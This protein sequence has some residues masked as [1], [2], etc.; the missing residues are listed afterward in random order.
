MGKNFSANNKAENRN[1]NDLYSTPKSLTRLF[2]D[3]FSHNFNIDDII[4]EPCY[5]K[6]AMYDVIREYFKGGLISSDI[7]NYITN[8]YDESMNF[9][10]TNN[11]YQKNKIEV[12]YIITNP[13][14]KL[15]TEFVYKCKEVANKGFTMLL[16]LSYLHGYA[17]YDTIFNK[18]DNYKLKT[19]DV[20]TRYPLLEENFSDDGT[21]STGM[22]V[23]SFMYWEKGYNGLPTIDWLDNNPFIKG[24]K[25]RLLKDESKGLFD[26]MY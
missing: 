1:K 14:Y 10:L 13:P 15:A 24:S 18:E 3:K 12:D 25:K 22:M 11:H 7:Y 21:H 6:G 16:P 17:R 2:L 20:F 26:G 4:A 9:L 23:Y 8:E 19:V 5:G